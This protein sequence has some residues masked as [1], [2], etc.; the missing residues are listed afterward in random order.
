[1][2]PL[3]I[4]LVIEWRSW[5]KVYWIFQQFFQQ[6][7]MVKFNMFFHGCYA[8]RFMV[9]NEALP[10]SCAHGQDFRKNYFTVVDNAPH[11]LVFKKVDILIIIH[12][13]ECPCD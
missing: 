6:S 5:G 10:T 11:N 1:M 12:L 9:C 8:I 13:E 3:F 7:R 4:E 2:C